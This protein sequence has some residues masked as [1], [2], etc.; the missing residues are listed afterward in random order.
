[1]LL[2]LH[3]HLIYKTAVRLFQFSEWLQFRF[4][5]V[6]RAFEVTNGLIMPD[7]RLNRNAIATKLSNLRGRLTQK[8]QICYQFFKRR[9]LGHHTILLPFGTAAWDSARRSPPHARRHPSLPENRPRQG[10]PTA[11]RPTM[12]CAAETWSYLFLS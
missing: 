8:T 11:A 1:M 9:N 12:E 3:R 2:N 6:K 4:S 5:I 7:I 10:W